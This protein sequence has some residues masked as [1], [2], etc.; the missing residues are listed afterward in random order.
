M[1]LQELA[2]KTAKC[3]FGIGDDPDC[4]LI[5]TGSTATIRRSDSSINNLRELA[6]ARGPAPVPGDA[7]ITSSATKSDNA[8][9]KY[10]KPKLFKAKFTTGNI[11]NVQGKPVSGSSSSPSSNNPLT[12][13]NKGV[14]QFGSVGLD[15]L[16][17]EKGKGHYFIIFLLLLLGGAFTIG[18]KEEN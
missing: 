3:V 1:N 12:R 17:L 9:S 18:E 10:N 7:N 15:P 11:N 14:D 8:F 5:A 2:V 16:E 13:L 6:N 4:P